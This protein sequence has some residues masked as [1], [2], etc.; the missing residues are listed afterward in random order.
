M[1]FCVFQAI[2]VETI[3]TDRAQKKTKQENKAEVL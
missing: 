3:I 1:Q 2:Q